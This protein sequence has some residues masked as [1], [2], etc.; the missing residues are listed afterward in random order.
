MTPKITG[1]RETKY[2]SVQQWDELWR[3]ARTVRQSIWQRHSNYMLAMRR[4]MKEI[5]ILLRLQDIS[6]EITEQEA[7]RFCKI[8]GFD[9]VRIERNLK[10]LMAR[11]GEI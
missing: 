3:E 11:L 5:E 2:L 1:I 9:G 6:C 4:M 10:E 7:L 8:A